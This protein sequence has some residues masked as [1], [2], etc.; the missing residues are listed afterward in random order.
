M[1][2]KKALFFILALFSIFSLHAQPSGNGSAK[3]VVLVLDTAGSMMSFYNEVGKFLSGPFL[4]ENL[5]INDTLHIISFGRKPRLEIARRVLGRGDIETISGRMWLLY[6]VESVSDSAAALTYTEQ[7]L[8]SIPGS[9]NKTIFVVSDSDL[10]AQVSS[11]NAR[12]RDTWTF[13]RASARISSAS[14]TGQRG[15]S[16]GISGTGAGTG[17]VTGVS[18]GGNN[19]GNPNGSISGTDGTVGGQSGAA[20]GI[21]GTDGINTADGING[22]NDIG[23]QNQAGINGTDGNGGSGG[24]TEGRLS[25]SPENSQGSNALGFELPLPLL[26]AIGLLLLLVVLVIIILM[27]RRLHASPN[28]VMAAAGTVGAAGAGAGT[29]AGRAEENAADLLNRFATRQAEASLKGPRRRYPYQDDPNQFLTNPP[30]LNLFV[31]EQNTAI[32]KRNVHAL[33]KGSVYSVGGANSDFLIFLVPIPGRIGQ[34]QYDGTNC[35]FT[36]LKPKYFPDIASTPVNE[37]IGKPIRILSD[38]NYEIFFHFE[39]Y[40]DPLIA[41]NQLLHSIQVPEAPQFQR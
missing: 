31:E 13:I 3:D 6:P 26:I 32:G 23:G 41:L 27:A 17:S 37:C 7:Y 5:N 34:L 18:T 30:I 22:T 29:I 21:N 40:R 19:A 1:K 39:R 38:K 28:K 8:Q 25:V 10:S 20:N 35:T 15:Q 24:L 36:P 11:V 2:M 4:A 33:K 12:Q 14:T 16:Q 9:R